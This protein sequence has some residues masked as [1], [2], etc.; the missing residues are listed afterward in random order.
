VPEGA[1]R[2]DGEGLFPR[3]CSDGTRGDERTHEMR[4]PKDASLPAR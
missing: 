2:K 1:D 4:H 3:G